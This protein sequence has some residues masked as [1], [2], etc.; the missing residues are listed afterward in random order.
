MNT[1]I[2]TT[3]KSNI[4]L[5]AS[6][7]SPGW[8]SS[9]LGKNAPPCNFPLKKMRRWVCVSNVP[10][11]CWREFSFS[12]HLECWRNRHSLDDWSKWKQR[13]WRMTGGLLWLA[14]F[15]MIG[16]RHISR[17]FFFRRA[18]EK[19]SVCSDFQLLGELL[20]RL[21]YSSPDSEHWWEMR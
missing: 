19:W 2:E 12:F 10:A 21:L 16:I 13:A 14:Q 6:A 3:K 18:E 17:S 20:M 15:I 7:L 1:F 11:F 4:T 5:P 9:V 8:H